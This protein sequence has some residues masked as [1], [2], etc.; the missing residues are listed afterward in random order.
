[1]VLGTS[2]YGLD[3]PQR[4]MELLAAHLALPLRY[5]VEE[6]VLYDDYII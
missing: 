1:M 3:G 5:G 4:I 6:L 2:Y